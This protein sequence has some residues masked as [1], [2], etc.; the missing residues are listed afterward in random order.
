MEEMPSCMAK[1][2][3]KGKKPEI[4][5]FFLFFYGVSTSSIAL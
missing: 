2:G 4:I 1:M 5:N 3:I